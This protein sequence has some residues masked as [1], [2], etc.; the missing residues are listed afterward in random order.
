G[1]ESN[2]SILKEIKDA[3]KGD[4][5]EDVSDGGAKGFSKAWS[6]AAKSFKDSMNSMNASGTGVFKNLTTSTGTFFKTFW[7]G[8]STLG[9][10]SVVL[11]AVTTAATIAYNVY[12]YF[13][14]SLE[15][16]VEKSEK[17]AETITSLSDNFKNTEETVSNISERFA[18]LAQG[19]DML[20]GKNVNLSTDEYEEFLS[21]SNQLAETFPT[22][23]R[24]YDENGNAIVQLGGSIDTIVDRLNNLV[25]AQRNL[26]NMQITEQ[27]PDLYKGI[28]A[29]SEE[30]NK[31]IKDLKDQ[32]E[33]LQSEL[34]Y[35]LDDHIANNIDIAANKI[36]TY[37]DNEILTIRGKGKELS[38]ANDEYLEALYKTGALITYLGTEYND[39]GEISS[40]KYQVDFSGMSDEEIEEAKEKIEVGFQEI[41]SE[42]ES[43]INNLSTEI[44]TT[45]NK[46]K[47]NWNGLLSN[48]SSWLATDQTY[49]NMDDEMRSIVQSIINNLDFDSLTSDYSTWDELSAYIHENILNTLAGASNKDEIKE[50]WNNLFKLDVSDLSAKEYVSKVNEY[51]DTIAN[52]LDLDEDGKKELLISIGI[53]EESLDTDKI[54]TWQ[55]QIKNAL[56]D[57]TENLDTLTL[58][59]LQ[60]AAKITADFDEN[61]INWDDLSTQINIKK[62]LGDVATSAQEVLDSLNLSA[63]DLFGNDKEFTGTVDDYISKVNEL[64]VALKK[65]DD[66]TLDN[67]DL[68]RLKK[69]GVETNNIENLDDAIRQMLSDMNTDMIAQFSDQFGYVDSAEARRELESFMADVVE[70]GSVVGS[71]KFEINIDTEK[72]GYENLATAMQESVSA[73]G[74]SSESISNLKERYAELES[75]GYD[76][77][78]MFEETTNGI[79]LNRQAL[80]ELE[81]AYE[82]QKTEEISDK[83]DELNKSYN[84]LTNQIK[85]CTD[86]VLLQ[87]LYTRRDEIVEEMHSVGEL[88]AQYEGLT[89]AYNKWQ[90]EQNAGNERD[91]YEGII[92][93]KKEME[94]EMERGWFDDDTVAFLELMTG[95]NLS[96]A[97]IDDQIA[98]YKKLNDTIAGTKYNVW[99]FFTTNDDGNSTSEGVFNFLDTVKAK[100]EELG[101]EWVKIDK[102]GNYTFDFGVNG[103]QAIADALGI[104][105]ELVQIILRAADDA[106]F[107]VNLDGAYTQLADYKT[108]AEE[109]ADSLKRL[110][111]EENK[112]QGFDLDF[113]FEATGEELDEQITKANELLDQFRDK[114]G[115]VNL[116][117]EGA[118]EALNIAG[119]FTAM[120]DRLNE[121]IY[122]DIKTDEVAKELQE[123][124]EKLQEFEKLT[125]KEHQLQLS[126]DTDGLK[127]V[128]EQMDE[129]ISYIDE[130]DDLKVVLGIDENATKD[131]IKEKLEN[132]EIEFPTTAT[133]DVE[134]KMNDSLEDIR[135][136]MMHEAGLISDE[137]LELKV[138]YGLDASEVESWTPEQQEAVVKYL[139][140]HE[141]IDN[142]TPEEKQAIVKYLADGG[143]PDAYTPEQKQAI[144]EYLTDTGDPDTWTPEQKDGIVLFKRDSKD[145]D[146]WTPEDKEAVAKFIK[147]S[148]E[149]DDYDPPKKYLDVEAQLNSRNVDTYQP[150]DKEFT[151]KAVLQKTWSNINSALGLNKVNSYTPATYAAGTAT[152]GSTYSDY[153]PS[154][155]AYARGTD[156]TLPQNE[157]ALVN[158]LGNESIVRDGKW[159]LIPGGAH[160]EQLKR[161][162]IVFNAAQTE[163]LIRTGKVTSGGGHGKVALAN[164]TA[165]NMINAYSSGG[166]VGKYTVSGSVYKNSSGQSTKS[167]N[168]DSNSNNANKDAEETK[169][170]FDWIE[171]KIQDIEREI[172]NLDQ[173][174]SATYKS[175]TTRN[176]ALVSEMS[177]ITKEISVQQAAYTRYMKEANS[178]GLSS[179]YKKLV[180]DGAI[181]ISTIKDEDL[182]DKIQTYQDFYDKAISAKD[183]VKDLQDQLAELARTKFDNVVQQYEDK[184]STVEHNINMLEGKIDQ[185]EAKGSIPARKYYDSLITQEKKN[186]SLLKQE[187]SALQKQLAN[188]MKTGD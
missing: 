23:S 25:E 101:E 176:K 164:G 9:K 131:E 58:S 26:T 166:S 50:A 77:D 135:A 112:L 149:V 174:A 1:F 129:I 180:Q 80:N 95:K 139:A 125:K 63:T 186:I 138:K 165:Y 51:M 47:E 2:K 71:T 43:Q 49:A 178:V 88:A 137:E 85:E 73:T 8:L 36:D 161:G 115:K 158:E 172:E 133:V 87:E 152:I 142:Y 15:E 143:N 35:L 90:I 64:R 126:G 76:L 30:Y 31:E 18:E 72:A 82:A 175:W 107:V 150:K 114:D 140:D 13:N 40:Y 157:E 75:Q 39:D 151:V 188:S 3:L 187:Y 48:L 44:E 14:D 183:T 45:Q 110:Q 173:K 60:I 56:S 145:I 103:D 59:D 148:E 96:T 104:S 167:S 127:D 7:S 118:E 52:T 168:S 94:E 86:P 124:L 70:L 46:N 38:E 109:A 79:H 182:I 160:V 102:D 123:P 22:L 57:G 134:I 5:A 6:E 141:E 53:D 27:M 159:F 33:N 61:S 74:L 66:G 55:S 163:E 37:A 108:A 132:G 170:T 92:S 4:D 19:V 29:Q 185:I 54:E 81:D 169:E 24:V 11:G 67:S 153:H 20:T 121:P 116:E 93:G 162:D 119:Y 69:L 105:E 130:N 155:G 98:A 34:D 16:L 136:L 122:M 117:I 113:N 28:A 100:Q 12:D 181:D 78:E 32:R 171:R 17:A 154:I 62:Y 83:V 177:K 84:A 120:Y 21:L 179:K 156:W 99:D 42:Y 65:L 146:D 68:D 144:V 147:D 97:S 10:V 106:G 128:Q 41:A 89:S 184:I 111:S 91:M